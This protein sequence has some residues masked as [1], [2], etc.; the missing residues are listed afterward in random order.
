VNFGSVGQG[1][2][3]FLE[4][5]L[6]GLAIQENLSDPCTLLSNSHDDKK[7]KTAWKRPKITTKDALSFPLC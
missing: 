3:S 4:W 6:V 2:D 7:Q 1:A 5:G